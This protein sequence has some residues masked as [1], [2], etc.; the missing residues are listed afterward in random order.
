MRLTA[1]S[2]ASLV[3]LPGQTALAA[4]PRNKTSCER[5]SLVSTPVTRGRCPVQPDAFLCARTQA[6]QQDLTSHAGQRYFEGLPHA[7]HEEL[8]ASL[9]VSVS[10]APGGNVSGWSCCSPASSS[11]TSL[12]RFNTG[13]SLLLLALSW[14]AIF[15]L[16]FLFFGLVD[17]SDLPF[18][19][20][21]YQFGKTLQGCRESPQRHHV[22]ES[23]MK[24][25]RSFVQIMS[26]VHADTQSTASRLKHKLSLS[27]LSSLSL[28]FFLFCSSL[29][30]FFFCFLLV[31]PTRKQRAHHKTQPSHFWL[32]LT[33]L[34][35]TT[36]QRQ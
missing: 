34:N 3:W 13:V 29:S 36:P 21:E 25:W 12:A 6:K 26:E 15:F 17:V 4:L 24:K 10:F 18:W 11:C 23:L 28:F 22:I 32:V 27:S 16:F 33:I 20:R 7:W 30:F 8:L 14:S 31:D 9:A 5:P 1:W 2:P 19:E 35:P